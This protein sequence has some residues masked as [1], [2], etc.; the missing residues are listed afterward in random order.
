M[1]TEWVL[2]GKGTGYG[3]WNENRVKPQG[4][5][6]LPKN[7]ILIYVLVRYGEVIISFS[8]FGYF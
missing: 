3:N 6:F 5:N 4:A 7:E 1:R 8:L 2:W